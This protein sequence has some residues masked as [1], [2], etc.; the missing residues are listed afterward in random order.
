MSKSGVNLHSLL[1]LL[2]QSGY[3]LFSSILN[4]HFILITVPALKAWIAGE[5]WPFY[6]PGFQRLR[7][8]NMKTAFH[9][10]IN[11]KVNSNFFPHQDKICV[12]LKQEKNYIEERQGISQSL[13]RAHWLWYASSSTGLTAHGSFCVSADL[14]LG[15]KEMFCLWRLKK[16]I[17][18]VCSSC[19]WW[20]DVVVCRQVHLNCT[21]KTD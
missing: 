6:D 10:N 8:K 11:Y 20:G 2:F 12:C 4:R 5:P 3:F 1:F 13:E 14:I 21:C 17:C 19:E 9:K 15:A 7:A 16:Y 18:S